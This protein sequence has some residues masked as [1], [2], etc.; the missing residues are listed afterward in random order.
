MHRPVKFRQTTTKTLGVAPSVFLRI[1][2]RPSVGDFAKYMRF[3]A[4][5]PPSFS[6]F[7]HMGFPIY[8]VAH[9]RIK[10][11]KVDRRFLSYAPA[12]IYF[13]TLSRRQKNDEKHHHANP[14]QDQTDFLLRFGIHRHV[15]AISAGRAFTVF[16][17]SLTF[18]AMEL[19][20][21]RFRGFLFR[22]RCRFRVFRLLFL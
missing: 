15:I 17:Q 14:C 19:R 1:F 16:H 18:T 12:C 4:Y 2:T 10:S 20:R 5:L 22:F 3:N 21:S 7:R 13:R 9:I 8:A 6:L 11:T